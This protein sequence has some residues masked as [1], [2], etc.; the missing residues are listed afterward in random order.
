MSIKVQHVDPKYI[1]QVWPI[2]GPLLEPIFN[3][4]IAGIGNINYSID[5]LKEYIIRG[6][7]TLLVGSNSDNSILGCVTIQW[8]NYPCARI[9]HVSAFGGNF[10]K[11]VEHHKGFIDWLK[12]M[13]ATRI[14]CSVRPSVA[15]LLQQKSGYTPTKQISMELVL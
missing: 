1:H 6:E 4:S 13:G 15:R 2:V 8:L 14:E 10:G 11:S 7:H 12:A 3:D 9:A 5:N